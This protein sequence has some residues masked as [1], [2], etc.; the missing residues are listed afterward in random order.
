MG[1]SPMFPNISYNSYAFVVNHINI[2]NTQKILKI[3]IKV[4]KKIITVLKAFN[5]IGCVNNFQIINSKISN[6][7]FAYLSVPFYRNTPFFKSIRLVSTGSKK[8]YLS[9]K[10]L[11]LVAPTL[12]SSIM[13]LSANYGIINHRE[14]LRKKVGGLILYILH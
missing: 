13:F 6:E 12:N 4:N 1:S 7:N 14:A 5:S 3:K 11:T 2:L 10:A 8:Y 9:F